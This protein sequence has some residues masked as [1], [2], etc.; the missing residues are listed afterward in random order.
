MLPPA[1]TVC[2]IGMA[3]GQAF[4]AVSGSPASGLD[5]I[6]SGTGLAGEARVDLEQ[7]LRLA[8]CHLAKRNPDD[9]RNC[10]ARPACGRKFQHF[11]RR[12]TCPA[13]GSTNKIAVASM[14]LHETRCCQFRH[15]IS[16][17]R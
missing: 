15:F 1:S 9:V 8:E 11:M 16:M 4:E 10:R 7:A 14:S 3:T 6:A 2:L 13:L 12:I 5:L 17:L